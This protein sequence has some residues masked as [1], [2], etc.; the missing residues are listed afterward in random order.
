SFSWRAL[1][2]GLLVTLAVIGLWGIP[3]LLATHGEFFE[4][5]IGRHV[6]H[7]SFA[8][9]EGHGGSGWVGYFLTLPLYFLTFF[10]SFFPL[11]LKVPRALRSWWTSRREDLLGC[12]LLA[13]AAVVFAVFTLIKTKLPHYTMPALPCVALWL[14]LFLSKARTFEPAMAR[15]VFVM[16]ALA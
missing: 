4:V 15:G 7:R 10:F 2:P 11:A 14:G 6:I 5:G 16:T 3:A 1:L 8:A 9:M 12:Y 13:Q